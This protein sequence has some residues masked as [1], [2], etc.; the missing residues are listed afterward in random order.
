MPLPHFLKSN[1]QDLDPIYKSLAEAEFYD[2][3]PISILTEQLYKIEGNKMYFHLN[4]TEDK[5]IIPLKKI[6]ELMDSN[7]KLM[8]NVYFHDK[9]GEVL[10]KVDLYGFRFIKLLNVL[11]YDWNENNEIKDLVVE[12]TYDSE[13]VS[14]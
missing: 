7:V 2:T 9:E 11:D 13:F 1:K 12:F 5:E 6:V 10:Y 3:D 4:I 14:T 8:V